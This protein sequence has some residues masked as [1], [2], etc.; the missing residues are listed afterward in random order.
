MEE[1]QNMSRELK[2]P[3]E[4]PEAQCCLASACPVWLHDRKAAANDPL[5][6]FGGMIFGR[7]N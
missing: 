5:F 6:F 3:Y 2:C 4:I 7:R 1:V